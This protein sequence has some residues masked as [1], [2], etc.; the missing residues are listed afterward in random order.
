MFDAGL[1]Q[2]IR[3]PESDVSNGPMAAHITGFVR[4]VMGEILNVVP[5]G[6][7]VLNCVTDGI[8]TNASLD[9]LDLSGELCRRFQ[10][11]VDTLG[12]KPC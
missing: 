7:V 12:G 5:G 9:E 3:V 1:E 4:A 8:L 11:Y 6:R 10:S 2:S